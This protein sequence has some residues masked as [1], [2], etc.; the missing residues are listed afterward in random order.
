MPKDEPLASNPPIGAMIDYNLAAAGPVEITIR[1]ASG[2][3]VNHFSS[4]DPVKPIDLSKL[5]IAPEW[6]VSS[7]P[8]EARPGQ[9][10]FVWDL[11]YAR[12]ADLNDNDNVRSGVWAPPGRY[13]VELTAG[14]QHLRQPLEV[15]ADP[16]VPVTQADFEA[17][18]RLAK[19]IEQQRVRV[20]TILAQAKG[21]KASLAKLKGQSDAE[22]LSTQLTELV[23]DAAPISGSAAPTNLTS[24]SEWLDKLA[25]AVDGADGAPTP[26]DVQGLATVT[27]ALNTL[28]PR[29][30]ALHERA[31]THLQPGS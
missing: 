7:R 29:W 15:V 21:L 3:V 9:H 27:A 26:D 20:R 24:V 8:P 10:R 17:E 25:G 30:N 5:P 11:H 12:P 16:R 6:V 19:Q 23:G 14:G 31:R 1:D 28:Q 22:A 13:T 4:S 18:F 2:N